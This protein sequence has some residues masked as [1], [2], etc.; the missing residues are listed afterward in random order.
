MIEYFS[1]YLNINKNKT[2][3]G[4]YLFDTRKI[5][6]I[7]KNETRVSHNDSKRIIFIQI[8]KVRHSNGDWE[9]DDQSQRTI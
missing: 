5:T 6:E 9:F 3:A 4:D 2:P 7:K 1:V 8:H